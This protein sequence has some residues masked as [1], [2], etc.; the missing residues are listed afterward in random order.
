VDRAVR[1]VELIT[2]VSPAPGPDRSARR[3]GDVTPQIVIVGQFG[4]RP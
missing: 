1:R 3:E 4:D 2:V